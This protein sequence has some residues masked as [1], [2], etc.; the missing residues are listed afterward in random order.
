MYGGCWVEKGWERG[1]GEKK[2]DEIHRREAVG[3]K[4]E[5]AERTGYCRGKQRGE[6]F[7]KGEEGSGEAT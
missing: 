3:R 1:G 4:K 5:K 7:K 6:N 2:G